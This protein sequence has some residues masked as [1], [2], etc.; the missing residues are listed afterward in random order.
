MG[1]REDLDRGFDS[2]VIEES[3]DE[4]KE[5]D[6]WNVLLH[7][8]DYTTKMFVVE[9]LSSVFHMS[10]IEATKFMMYVHKNGRGVAGTYTW[11]I[12]QT[13]V[14]RVHEM[15]KKREFPLRC[16]TEKA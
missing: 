13:K 5:P 4:T 2:N 3:K 16:S 1:D 14:T 8:D 6:M 9:V 11:D 15:A 10:A 12:S 7:N